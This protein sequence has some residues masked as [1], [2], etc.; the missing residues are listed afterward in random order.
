MVGNPA[1]TVMTSSPGERRRSPS[2]WLVSAATASRFADD[3]EFTSRA[4]FTPYQSA[5]SVSSRRCQRP[6]VSQN[7]AEASARFA[8]SSSP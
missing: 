2:W 5:S 8:I 4:C 1:A 3:P 7:S 6:A